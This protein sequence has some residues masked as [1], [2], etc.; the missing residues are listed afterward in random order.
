IKSL[1]VSES[2]FSSLKPIN[3]H[4]LESG[5]PESLVEPVSPPDI[6][7]VPRLNISRWNPESQGAID[8]QG[9][10]ASSYLEMV[11]LKIET[12]KRYPKIARVRQI[13]GSVTIYFIITPAGD[14][15]SA[16]VVKSSAFKILDQ[17]ALR[18]VEDASP[19]PIPPAPVFSGEI[20]LKISL[21]FELT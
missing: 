9:I 3:I 11:R 17:A 10:T 4:P 8:D 7:D 18:A 14:A 12:H 13:E 5:L 16:R 21:V 1:N 15:K 6:P 20:P 19:F 2:V